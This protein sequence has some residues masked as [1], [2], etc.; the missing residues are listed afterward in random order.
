MARHED[1]I[2]VRHYYKQIY[3]NEI[4]MTNKVSEIYHGTSYDQ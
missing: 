2:L 4:Q 1:Q 3:I